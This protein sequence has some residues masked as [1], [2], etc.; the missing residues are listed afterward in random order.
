MCMLEI[1]STDVVCN[2]RSH[3]DVRALEKGNTHDMALSLNTKIKETVR[4]DTWFFIWKHLVG[5]TIV[6]MH[7]A[8]FMFN[9]DFSEENKQNV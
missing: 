5:N 1:N 6:I 9:M 2:E 7:T 3:L 8:M 4:L